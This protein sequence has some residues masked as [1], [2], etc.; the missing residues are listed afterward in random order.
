MLIEKGEMCCDGTLLSFDVFF[1]YHVLD[2]PARDDSLSQTSAPR[3][4]DLWQEI[5]R[6]F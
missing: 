5:L 3:V 2:S 1:G 4:L 6:T